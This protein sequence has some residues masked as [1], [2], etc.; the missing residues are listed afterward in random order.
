MA[1]LGEVAARLFRETKTGWRGRMGKGLKS[2][3]TLL[4]MELNCHR[5]L[6]ALTK[7]Q[8]S[9]KAHPGRKQTG[10][11]MPSFVLLARS[12][13]APSPFQGGGA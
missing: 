12:C 10:G 5:A 13:P 7:G 3:A 8:G 1:F 11:K 2:V 9:L 4:H 6:T